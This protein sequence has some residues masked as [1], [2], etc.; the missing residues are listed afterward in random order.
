MSS[1][2]FD[3]LTEDYTPENDHEN[4]DFSED[5]NKTYIEQILTGNFMQDTMMYKP[6][7]IIPPSPRRSTYV[8][9]LDT[10]L[11]GMLRPNVW[12]ESIK[13][14]VMRCLEDLRNWH[15]DETGYKVIEEEDDE[16]GQ[17][18]EEWPARIQ[19]FEER[20][21]QGKNTV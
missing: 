10:W 4:D 20:M 11:Y 15:T 7:R 17:F 1:S 3:Q 16:M 19:A 14:F 21:Q 6:F 5:D 8:F 18:F 12:N 13:R 9:R 2:E